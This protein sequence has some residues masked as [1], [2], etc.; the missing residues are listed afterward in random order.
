MVSW[1]PG[2]RTRV[3]G[4]M[5][6]FPTNLRWAARVGLA[7]ALS[8]V[9]APKSVQADQADRETAVAGDAA[10]PASDAVPQPPPA[11]QVDPAAIAGWIEQLDDDRYA[12]RKSAQKSLAAVGAPALDA[13]GEVA[14]KGSLE[15][16]TRAVG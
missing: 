2:L 9:G 5:M 15:S 10:V 14:A 1:A 13:V 3:D 6:R 7:A 8:V 16:A 12:V 11:A 4:M